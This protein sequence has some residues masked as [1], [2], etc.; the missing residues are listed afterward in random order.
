[1]V[2]AL[3]QLQPAECALLLIGQQAGL[4]FGVGSTDCQILL[5]D[6]VALARTATAF[7]L[8]IVVSTSAA[9]VYSAPKMPAIHAVLPD[10]TVI[11]RRSM[12][13]WEGAS[14]T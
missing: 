11:E 8:P 5:N 3:P 1:M 4:A 12:N 14:T 9:K 7:E 2:D 13:L 6:T 10:V